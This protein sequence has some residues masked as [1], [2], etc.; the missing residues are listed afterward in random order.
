MAEHPH[1]RHAVSRAFDMMGQ[2]I[3]AAARDA[4]YREAKLLGLLTREAY[5]CVAGICEGLE[6]DEPYAAMAAA[7]VY[8]DLT[9][10]IRLMALVLMEAHRL[11]SIESTD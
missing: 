1:Q 6:R 8:V 11:D 3:P 7:L 4:C 2:Q 5:A 9:S 10:Y